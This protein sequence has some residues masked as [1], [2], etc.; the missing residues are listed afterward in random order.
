M[1]A[2]PIRLKAVSETRLDRRDRR[3]AGC[4]NTTYETSLGVPGQEVARRHPTNDRDPCVRDYGECKMGLREYVLFSVF[5][6]SVIEPDG[7]SEVPISVGLQDQRATEAR[8]RF[9]GP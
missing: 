8:P 9:F 4:R 3:S 1:T 5:G 2:A 6:R 7:G